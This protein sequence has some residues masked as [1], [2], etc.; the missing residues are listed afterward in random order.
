V[1]GRVGDGHEWI[2]QAI[3]LASIIKHQPF[4]IRKKLDAKAVVRYRAMT[5]A[6]KVAPLIKVA[7]IGDT[8]FLLDGWHRMEAGAL[9]MDF[10]EPGSVLALVAVM[11]VNEA[12]WV[13]ADANTKHGVQLKPAELRGVLKA[14]INAGKHKKPRG[15][16]MSYRELA[17]EIGKGHTTIR[18]WVQKDFPKLFERLGSVRA[19][20]M[21]PALPPGSYVSLDDERI[22]QAHEAARTLQQIGSV[23]TTAEARGDLMLILE[24]TLLVL[25]TTGSPIAVRAKPAATDRD[26]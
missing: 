26:F 2:E 18:G 10:A 11:G 21:E 8:Y 6:G 24:E 12:R 1:S 3:P 9:T 23:L 17:E 19:G 25:Q 20:N 4:Q 5:R 14:F 13:A 15:A 7:R 22:I 16:L